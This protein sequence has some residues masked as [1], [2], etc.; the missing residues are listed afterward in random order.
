MKL[1]DEIIDI[2]SSE[3]T[4]LENALI[5]TKVLLHKMGE[6]VLLNWIN[7]EINGYTKEDKIPEY[8][9]ISTSVY[10]TATNGYTTRWENHRLPIGHLS[11]KIQKSLSVQEMDE[12]IS[13]L[14]ILAKSKNTLSAP[15]PTEYCPSFAKGLGN[16]IYVESAYKQ[17]TQTQI[18]QILTQIR[19]RLLDFLLE[20]SERLEESS[21]DDIKSQSKKIGTSELFNHT[22]FGDNTTIIVGDNNSNSSNQVKNNLD[23]LIEELKNNKID[24]SEIEELK[25][26]IEKDTNNETKEYG[27]NVKNWFKKISIKAI[28]NNTIKGISEALNNFYDMI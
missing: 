26:S 6:K 7:N 18:V 14:E 3:N 10:G 8:R 22:I 21:D 17:I 15:L 13:A 1:I 25:I 20:L 4:N 9:I 12:S 28:E 16:G 5:K 27:E 24:E 23:K 2:L 11:K 19:N